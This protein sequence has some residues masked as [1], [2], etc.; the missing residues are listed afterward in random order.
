RMEPI[1]WFFPDQ[2]DLRRRRWKIERAGST[3]EAIQ[4]VLKPANK[5][6]EWKGEVW[7]DRKTGMPS[8]VMLIDPGS[9]D[10]SF[11]LRVTRLEENPPI[12]DAVFK[13]WLPDAKEGW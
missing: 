2:H 8:R 6:W 5:S 4:F 7:L 10:H 9:D 13:P 3:K 1:H 11:D 12:D